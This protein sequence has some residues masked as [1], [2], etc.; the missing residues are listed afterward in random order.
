[1]LHAEMFRHFHSPTWLQAGMGF[2]VYS[3]R[4]NLGFGD[5]SVVGCDALGLQAQVL[6][7]RDAGVLIL[8]S[9]G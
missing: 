1:M 6:S 3:G 2:G 7:F 9:L 4:E 5:A 8:L